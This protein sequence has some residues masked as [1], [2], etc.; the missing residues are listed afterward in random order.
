V[1][2]EAVE[3]VYPQAVVTP[4]LLT[5]TTDTRHY[6]DLAQNQYRFHGMLLETAQASSVHGTNEFITVDSFDKTVDIATAM[7]R[8][9]AQ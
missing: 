4:S 2:A 9:G 1:I 7:M 5:A 8:L 3:R 6:I